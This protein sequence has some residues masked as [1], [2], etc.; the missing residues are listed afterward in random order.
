MPDAGSGSTV[1]GARGSV[2]LACAVSVLGAIAAAWSILAGHAA[3]GPVALLG[4]TALIAAA[5]ATGRPG[6]PRERV[7][8]SIADRAYDGAILGAVVWVARADAPDLA[9]AAL[10]AYGLGTLAAYARARAC[11]LGYDLSSFAPVSVVRVAIVGL[12]LSLSWDTV[13]YVALAVWQFASAAIRVSQVW[14]EEL[15]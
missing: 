13:A 14:K 15:A 5:A 8:V 3:A 11:G 12:A 10:V 4:G 9:A 2:V 1:V 7:L 6:R